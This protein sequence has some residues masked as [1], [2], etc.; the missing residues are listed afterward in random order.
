[1]MFKLPATKRQVFPPFLQNNLKPFHIE[2]FSRF[3]TTLRAMRHAALYQHAIC[4]AQ[5]I[6]GIQMLRKA[7][8]AP[9]TTGRADRARSA[10]M[11]SQ[12][13]LNFS[14]QNG[15][16]MEGRESNIRTRTL[17]PNRQFRLKLNFPFRRRDGSSER[18]T[19][20]NDRKREDR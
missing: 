19:W 10:Q 4:L 2:G 8:V 20:R 7:Q 13:S 3:S 11:K 17:L 1:M 16:Q 14:F 18:R 9:I 12:V 6:N 5:L 15:N